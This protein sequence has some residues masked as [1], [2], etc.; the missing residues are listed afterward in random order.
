MWEETIVEILG[1][2]P[3][4]TPLKM[5]Y[6]DFQD[7]EK[8]IKIENYEFDCTNRLFIDYIE[9]LI[10]NKTYLKIKGSIYK[11]MKVKTCSDYMELYLYLLQKQP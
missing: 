4:N 6:G 9:P 7:F 1:D 10:D 3:L 5:L 8:I 11:V 2:T